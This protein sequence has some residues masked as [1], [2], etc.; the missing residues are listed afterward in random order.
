VLPELAAVLPPAPEPLGDPRAERHRLFRALRELLS[1]PGRSVLVLED[2]HWADEQTLE[3]LRFL[4]PQLPDE[5][6]LVCT[7]RGEDVPAASLFRSLGARSP[8]ARLE[9]RLRPL[10]RDE[11]RTLAG[12]ILEADAMSDEFADYLFQGSGGLPFAV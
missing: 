6:T 4:C 9:L 7:Y 11:V 10:D 12:S 5:L 3:F 1:S 2:L 8:I